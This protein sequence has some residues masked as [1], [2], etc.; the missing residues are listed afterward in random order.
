MDAT[1][2]ELAAVVTMVKDDYVFL[3]KWVAYYGGLFGKRALY[4]FNHGGDA[5]IDRIARGCNVIY[6]PGH[7][8]AMFDARR[9][10]LLTNLTNGLRAYYEFVICGDVDEFLVVDPQLGLSLP[11]FLEKRRGKIVITPIG[12][13]VVHRAVEEFDPIEPT[14]LGARRFGRYSSLYCKPCIT[15]APIRFSRGGHYSDHAELQVFRHLYLFHMKF[16]DRGLTIETKRRRMALA[17]STL[18]EQGEKTSKISDRWFGDPED[19]AKE[20]D[21]LAAMPVRNAF[22][23]SDRIEEMQ[24]SWA[25]R[26]G[27]FYHFARHEAKELSVIPERF[28]G[29]I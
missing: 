6:L 11:E 25:P 27:G 10:R 8:D 1:N 28:A 24:E 2:K 20:L 21:E 15:S 19:A 23:F 18:D 3:R 14:I 9:W 13:E 4:V 29:L 5:E 7:F 22:D 26:E 17:A 16:C 12:I